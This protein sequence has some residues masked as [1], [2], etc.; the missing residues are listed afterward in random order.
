[1]T[2]TKTRSLN[3]SRPMPTSSPR[4]PASVQYGRLVLD[5]AGDVEEL[6]F[7]HPALGAVEHLARVGLR[8]DPLPWPEAP[9]VHQCQQVRGHFP[10]PVPGVALELQVDLLLR[11]Q[12]R[13]EVALDVVDVDLG[14]QE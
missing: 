13:P 14:V 12:E 2:V 1:M 3:R 9:H 11:A 6:P 5:G 4:S 8:H 10:G 7:P